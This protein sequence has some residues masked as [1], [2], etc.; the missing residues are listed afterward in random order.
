MLCSRQ[1]D[2]ALAESK[3]HA[4]TPRWSKWWWLQIYSI[5]AWSADERRAVIALAVTGLLVF[6]IAWTAF[7]L[8]IAA[9]K[10]ELGETLSISFLIVLIGLGRTI[11]RIADDFFPDLVAKGDEAAARRIGGTVYFPDESPGIW[12]ASYRSM[13]SQSQEENFVI[14]VVYCVAMP[15][16][17]PTLIVLPPLLR[18]MFEVDK[19][20]S[21]IAT[22][23]TM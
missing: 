21:V 15:I 16:L 20:T 10:F 14:R 9:M 8:L 13:S 7:A 22:L 3:G 11:A 2:A 12:W 17:L 18:I 19:R 4:M 5:P 6:S 1:R 23:V